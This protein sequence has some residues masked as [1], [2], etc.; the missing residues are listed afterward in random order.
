HVL[1]GKTRN[2]RARPIIQSR[3][4]HAHQQS[5][6]AITFDDPLNSPL[7][8]LNMYVRGKRHK[9]VGQTR[10]GVDLRQQLPFPPAI[11]VFGGRQPQRFERLGTLKKLVPP[12]ARKKPGQH[13]VIRLPDQNKF[14][15]LLL[16]NHC[17]ALVRGSLEEFSDCA[18]HFNAAHSQRFAPL[19]LL[20]AAL[21]R[22][23][24][25][26]WLTAPSPS[27]PHRHVGH[28]ACIRDPLSTWGSGGTGRRA[29]LRI[30]WPKGR[31]GSTPSSRTLHTFNPSKRCENP[32]F[33]R[34]P[35]APGRSKPRQVCL[36][37]AREMR[38]SVPV[39]TVVWVQFEG[40]F[41]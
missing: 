31:G 27:P 13:C 19:P 35:K 25:V 15:A 3:R 10:F 29:R 40:N 12:F 16:N 34:L 26:D 4:V 30:L 28:I 9:A 17:A 37:E 39:A 8:K 7:I 18:P 23:S 20:C 14:I 38:H 22:Q 2:C 32:V 5:G 11:V 41:C 6:V 1:G 33:M 24:S 21:R 36:I